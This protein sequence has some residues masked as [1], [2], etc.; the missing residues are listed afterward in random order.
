MSRF[1]PY[2]DLKTRFRDFVKACCWRQRKVMQVYEK[3]DM[4]AV[5]TF[6][7]ATL[8]AKVRTAHDLGYEVHLTAKDDRLVVEYVKNLPDEPFIL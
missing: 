1:N 2:K 4:M 6:E 8:H 5:D 7:I 3:K